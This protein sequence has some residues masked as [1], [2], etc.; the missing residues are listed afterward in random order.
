MPSLKPLV[1]EAVPQFRWMETF[2][3]AAECRNYALAGE[4]LNLSKASVSMHIKCLEKHLETELFQRARKG[5][6][7]ERTEAGE[8]YLKKLR[9]NF[10]ELTP[11][12]V[13]DQIPLI[14]RQP[15]D[16]ASAKMVDFL[17]QLEGLNFEIGQNS[18]SHSLLS[19]CIGF[20][21]INGRWKYDWIGRRS[22]F[23]ECF[24]IQLSR[25]IIGMN[26]DRAQPSGTFNNF[27]HDTCHA[28]FLAHMTG[29]PILE[30][31]E[32]NIAKKDGGHQLERYQKITV[33]ARDCKGEIILVRV[34]I[35]DEC[36]AKPFSKTRVTKQPLS[37]LS[38]KENLSLAKLAEVW[39]D[40]KMVADRSL[41]AFMDSAVLMRPL[42]PEDKMIYAHIGPNSLCAILHGQDW[43]ET[44]KGGLFVAG[45]L[46]SDL[47]RKLFTPMRKCLRDG[48]AR[49]VHIES[50][51]SFPDGKIRSWNAQILFLRV[52]F[53]DGAPA[54]LFMSTDPIL[55][56]PNNLET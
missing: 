44:N 6:P 24:G 16:Q 7:L 39:R 17:T 2:L 47:R 48:N 18:K 28:Y 51:G 46:G 23:V 5:Q 32:C 25:K 38:A 33:K 53:G 15:L 30:T 29:E 27:D 26:A 13:S 43:C 55:S 37:R 54:I 34:I 12:Y 31:V 1:P 3:T 36:S 11:K 42:L 35:D 20:R 21:L 41:A 49:L 4:L 19:E 40:Q 22:S 14:T 56:D 9:Q 8:F 50:E 45:R 10:E 52:H